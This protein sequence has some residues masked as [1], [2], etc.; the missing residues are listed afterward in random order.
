[1]LNTGK[2][3]E[4]VLDAILEVSRRQAAA[5]ETM[6]TALE[7]GDEAAALEQ[8]KVLAGLKPFG[9]RKPATKH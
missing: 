5:L 7:Q 1:M 8:A 6:R 4:G 2:G 9:D 3:S